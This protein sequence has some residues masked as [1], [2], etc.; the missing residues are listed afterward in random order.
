MNTQY[1]AFVGTY[2]SGASE[3]VYVCRFDA[4]TGALDLLGAASG[5]DN[6]SF[7]DVA[8]SGRYLYVVCERVGAQSTGLVKAYAIDAASGRLTYL[9]EQPSRGEGPCHVRI[10]RSGAYAL[11]AN[12]R[13][14][15]TAMLPIQPDGTLGATSGFVQHQGRSVDPARQTEP[16]A[17][18]VTL[19]PANRFVFAADLGL[20][21]LLVYRLDL[22]AG[23]LT[24]HV[25]PWLR[26][27]PGA[28]PRHAA[29]H[30]NGQFVYLINEMGSSVSVLH[31][32]A[33]PG[34]L[35]EVETVPTLPAD[36]EGTSTC[37]DIHVHPSGR[38]VY[39]SNRGHDSIA[40]FAVDQA[41]G[42]LTSLGHEP[43]RGQTPR[44][45]ALDPTGTWLLAA[46]QDSNTIVTFRID[47]SSGRLD[48]AGRVL[49]L[50]SPVCIELLPV[51]P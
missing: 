25:Y 24:P 1:L 12:Y 22:D 47:P 4:A 16:H 32:H 33:A 18:S 43:T 48:A 37:A 7:L 36:F 21:K 9:N 3:G 13:S 39:G 10:D 17:H 14:G 38:F 42:R 40:M 30:P 35:S 11:L 15:S 51:A 41:T 2:T 23:T 45:F 31:Y 34:A 44:N 50:P 6:P 49:D 46:N 28:G 26:T 19:D 5:V 27:P 20:D 29:F 8:P